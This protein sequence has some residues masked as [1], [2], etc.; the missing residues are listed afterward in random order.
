MCKVSLKIYSTAYLFVQFQ[1]YKTFIIVL[2]YLTNQKII[3]YSSLDVWNIFGKNYHWFK[4]KN[5]NMKFIT[6]KHCQ[7]WRNDTLKG[8]LF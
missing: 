3:Q 8:I 5:Q 1:I 4:Y 7:Y 2:L 6:L